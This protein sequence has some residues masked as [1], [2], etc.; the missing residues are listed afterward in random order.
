MEQESVSHRFVLLEGLS[1]TKIQ[2]LASTR[3]CNWDTV[4]TLI[5]QLV[6]EINWPASYIGFHIEDQAYTHENE[7]CKRDDTCLMELYNRRA[8][9][10]KPMIIR[11]VF[12]APPEHF[13][14]TGMCICDFP[15]HGCCHT[16]RTDLHGANCN[17]WWSLLTDNFP[18]WPDWK[19]TRCGNNGCCQSGNCGHH[20]C[21][22]RAIS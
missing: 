21:E 5:S 7:F 15:G 3:I 12:K 4:G 17:H 13:T 16:G 22:T 20:C 2:T 8:E 10:Q 6:R 14:T 11:V 1:D 19:C 18:R 9:M